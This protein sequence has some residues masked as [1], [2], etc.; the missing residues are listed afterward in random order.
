M[1]AG[2]DHYDCFI[3]HRSEKVTVSGVIRAGGENERQLWPQ[4]K[5]ELPSI[6]QRP[7]LNSRAQGRLPLPH[8]PPTGPGRSETTCQETGS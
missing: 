2:H 7:E 6:H 5:A 1:R 8:P 3:Y 4:S